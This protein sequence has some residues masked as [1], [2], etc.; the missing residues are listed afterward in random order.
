MTTLI[1][2]DDRTMDR[3]GLVALLEAHPDSL[4]IATTDNARDAY[5]KINQF[6]PDIAILSSSID[7]GGALKEIVDSS[8]VYS[9]SRLIW[10]TV[11]ESS[12]ESWHARKLGI[13]A[14]L[15]RENCFEDLLS[16]ITVVLHGGEFILPPMKDQ[17]QH[18]EARKE[19]SSQLSSREKDVLREVARGLTA[20]EIARDLALSPRTIETYKTRIMYKLGI[21]GTYGLI[22]YALENDL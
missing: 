5:L 15:S 6:R 11:H 16:A 13:P 1:V 22:R 7:Y 18:M 10:L 4:V 21:R 2:A 3:Q 9:E 14:I 12:D 19:K 20:K 8:A 17:L